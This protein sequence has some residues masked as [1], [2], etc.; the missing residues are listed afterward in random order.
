MCSLA[1]CVMCTSRVEQENLLQSSE[2]D[3]IAWDQQEATN[4][5]ANPAYLSVSD[6]QSFTMTEDAVYSTIDED[7]CQNI[8]QHN[9]T[10]FGLKK[11][12]A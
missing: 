8:L 9:P 11:S 3:E 6:T 5:Q 10:Y 7:D 1:M 4:L 2:A 12:V